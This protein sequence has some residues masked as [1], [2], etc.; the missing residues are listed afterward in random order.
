MQLRTTLEMDAGFA[1]AHH[2]L[3]LTYGALGLEKEA[4]HHLEEAL[5]FSEDNPQVLSSLGHLYGRIGNHAAAREVLARLIRQSEESY[6]TAA[7]MAEVCIGFGDVEEAFRWMEEALKE[8]TSALLRLRI[9][10]RFDAL[11][12]TPRFREMF[13]RVQPQATAQSQG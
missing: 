5:R 1:P 7:S 4:I 3:G 2:R 13:Q 8:R 11:R 9:D 12:A 6:V 10:P